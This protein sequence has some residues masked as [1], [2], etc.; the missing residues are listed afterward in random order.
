SKLGVVFEA[1]QQA[2]GSTKRKYGGTGLGLSISR[3]LAHALGGEIHVASEEGKGSTFS[4]YLPLHFEASMVTQSERKVDIKPRMPELPRPSPA[5]KELHVDWGKPEEAADDRY[6]V[7]DTDKLVLILED[8][9]DF[10]NILLDFVRERNYKGIVATE[11]NAGLSYARHYK[12]DAIIL[13]MK[14][15]QM[16]GAE[17]LRHLKNDP[18]LRHVPVQIISGY[19]RRKEGLE[20][21]AF[22]FI[23]K[24]ISHDDL[25][26][27]FEKIEEFVSRKL[28]KLL[29]V[30]DD[31]MQNTAIR[32]LIGN[33]DVKCYSAY[34]GHEGFDMMAK[35]RYDCVII[36]LGLPDMTGLDLLEKIKGDDKLRRVPIIVYTGKDLSRQENDK[37]MK[38]ANTVVLKTANSHERLLDETT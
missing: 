1:F 28:K 16:D 20:L 25:R 34:S 31:R 36:D 37:L 13:D 18:E 23:Q 19:D 11:G 5:A 38:F 6:S 35:E 4:L 14:L 22:D 30:E 26:K 24:P 27:A 7:R 2:D 32:E 33:G 15:P 8:D 17:V 9:P 21:G 29:I 3:E 12:P 10:S